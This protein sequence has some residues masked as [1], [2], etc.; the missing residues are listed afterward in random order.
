M[1]VSGIFGSLR[2]LA[3]IASIVA[4]MAVVHILQ[5]GSYL[6]GEWYNSRLL[7]FWTLEKAAR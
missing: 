4:L 2:R 1:D 3:V 7:G 5:V 6:Q